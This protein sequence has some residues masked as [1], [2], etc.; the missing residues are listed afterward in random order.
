MKKIVSFLLAI[1]IAAGALI[2]APIQLPGLIVSANAEETTAP[3]ETTGTPED[4]TTPVEEETGEATPVPEY[5]LTFTLLGSGNEYAVSGYTGNPVNLIIPAEHE[6]IP[7]K[8]IAD[9]VFEDCAS[10]KTIEIPNTITRIGYMSF[11]GCKTLEDL[12]IPGSVKEIDNYAFSNCSNLKT[13][14]FLDGADGVASNAFESCPSIE[15]INL[16]ETH[17]NLTAAHFKGSVIYNDRSN[18]YGNSFYIENQL[19]NTTWFIHGARTVRPGTTHINTRAFIGTENLIAVTIPT[20]V[21]HIGDDAFKNSSVSVI[22]YEGTESQFKQIDIG[23]NGSRF[24]DIA[25]I[26]GINKNNIPKTPKVKSVSNVAGGVRITWNKVSNADIYAVYRRGSG[27]TRWTLLGVTTETDVIDTSAEHRKF[28]RYSVQA[29]NDNGVS[30]FD[31]NGKYLKYIETP[32]LTGLYNKAN[33]MQLTWNAVEG[34]SGY[35]VYR[36]AAGQGWRYLGTVKSTAYLDKAVKNHNGKYYRYTVRA[37]VDKKYSGYEDYL[38]TMRL[39]AP[40]LKSCKYNN[41]TF[42]LTL[43]WEAAPSATGYYIYGYNIYHKYWEYIDYVKGKN[44]TSY[45]FKPE[46]D[47]R[48]YSKYS[49]VSANGKHRSEL[50]IKG[51]TVR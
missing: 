40:K 27:T 41:N 1:V 39:T 47:S 29:L 22:Y 43:K 30:S 6:G 26:C 42:R 8:V 7:V 37:V 11:F 9:R 46:D 14:T 23:N 21:K 13:L 34:A 10:L 31:K 25:I 12:T 4:T 44:T 24:E 16:P 48:K 5:E 2:A 50:N 33:G 35:R 45:T 15:K 49:V 38:Y 32:K 19:I 17:V 51:I 36:R 20:S 3:E 18:W 28:W